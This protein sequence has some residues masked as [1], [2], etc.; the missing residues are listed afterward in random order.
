MEFINLPC[1]TCSLVYISFGFLLLI[2]IYNIFA[3][4]GLVET[5][6]NIENELCINSHLWIYSLV[7]LILLFKI[8][9]TLSIFTNNN[10]LTF[11]ELLL[12]LGMFIWGI[13]EFFFVKCINKLNNTLLYKTTFAYW[14]VNIFLLI[15]IFGLIIYRVIIQL[16]I[17]YS[18]YKISLSDAS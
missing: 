5:P 10:I 9:I 16:R 12:S 11:F 4:I 3:I 17:Y 13:Y 7:S 2:I 8:K 18:I 15:L 6:L 1:L 14:I